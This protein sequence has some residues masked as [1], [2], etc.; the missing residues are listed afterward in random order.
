MSQ[1]KARRAKFFEQHPYCC[2]C[3]GE[4]LATTEDHIPGRNIFRNR[5]WPEGFVFP[6]CK[7]C[8][9][10]SSDDELVV[11]FLS[12]L[13]ERQRLGPI[14][15]ELVKKSSELLRQFPEFRDSFLKF[16]RAEEKRILRNFNSDPWNSETGKQR[17]V[18]QIP[19]EIFKYAENFGIKLGKALH[20]L[21]HQKILPADAH[22]TCRALSNADLGKLNDEFFRLANKAPTNKNIVRS[23][24]PLVDQFVYKYLTHHELQVGLYI[25]IFGI[26]ALTLLITV[27]PEEGFLESQN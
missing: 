1:K 5:I 26:D 14:E 7:K 10:E 12:R 19:R 23:A 20:Y 27:E 9:G 21:H 2:F 3:G 13:G 15:S 16:S 25:V 6:A 17:K 22:V 24:R 18:L 8:N 11:A 4:E